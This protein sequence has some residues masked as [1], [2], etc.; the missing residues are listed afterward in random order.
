MV[1]NKNSG[2]P[3]IGKVRKT[4]PRTDEGKLKCLISAGR[5]TGRTK[6]RILNAFRQCDMCPLAPKVVE[7]RIKGE[8]VN[9]TMPGKCPYFQQHHECI[10]PQDVFIKKLRTYYKF[11]KHHST[12]ELQEYLTYEMLENAELAKETEMLR[13][14]TPGLN[15]A[16]FQE[17]ASKNLTDMNKL[18]HGEKHQNLNMNVDVS[19]AIINAYKECK[20]EE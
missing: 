13:F 18:I 15:T 2:N 4:G 3:D 1:G 16:K 19:Q 11:I 20:G 10:F 17:L 12:L 7:K 6:S 14:R 5:V 9:V 8:R